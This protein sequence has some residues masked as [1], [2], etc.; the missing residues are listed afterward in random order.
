MDS[1]QRLSDVADDTVCVR[2]VIGSNANQIDNSGIVGAKNSASSVGSSSGATNSVGFDNNL[3]TGSAFNEEHFQGTVVASAQG[4]RIEGVARTQ[5]DA[6]A[7]AE[8]NAAAADGNIGS[9]SDLGWEIEHVL[10]SGSINSCY[11]SNVELCAVIDIEFRDRSDRIIRSFVQGRVLINNCFGSS[12]SNI[13]F[14]SSSQGGGFISQSGSSCGVI[15]TFLLSTSIWIRGARRN[16]RAVGVDCVNYSFSGDHSVRC[17][18]DSQFFFC[19][20]N[21][22]STVAWDLHNFGNQ[23]SVFDSS[24]STNVSPQRVVQ[25]TNSCDGYAGFSCQ[26]GVVGFFQNTFNTCRR[27]CFGDRGSLSLLRSQ[28]QRSFGNHSGIKVSNRFSIGSSFGRASSSNFQSCGFGASSGCSCIGF[29]SR[30]SRSAD[31][32]NDGVVSSCNSGQTGVGS[33]AEG[34]SRFN[35]SHRTV[36]GAGIEGRVGNSGRF[37]EGVDG[38]SSCRHRV[39][40]AD[41]WNQTSQGT[42]GDSGQGG[43]YRSGSAVDASDN[44]STGSRAVRGTSSVNPSTVKAKKAIFK[45][46]KD[47]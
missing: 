21:Q 33:G 23:S 28:Y 20:S 37:G 4:A 7:S 42:V 19:G 26:R 2:Q 24:N 6:V 44:R 41:A 10:F 15:F 31:C 12:D 5:N 11:L 1:H 46:L 29:V 34:S 17:F 18:S 43:V 22:C 8:G 27:G 14:F 25:L 40:E 45:G 9:C 35:R 47:I 13:T 39:D 36:F 3:S 32:S 38:S 30:Q 16:S